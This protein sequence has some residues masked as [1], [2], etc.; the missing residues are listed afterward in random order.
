MAQ[1]VDSIVVEF[2]AETDQ[3][4]RR[5]GKVIAL[6]KELNRTGQQM[7]AGQKEYADRHNAAGASIAQA[8]EQTTAR[9]TRTRRKR[10]DDS[11]ALDRRETDAAKRAAKERADAEIAEAQRSARL[12]E[13]ARRGAE[14]ANAGVPRATNSTLGRTV[15][16]EA[17][18]Q[19]G[20]PAAVL[21]GGAEEVAA[22]KEV[23]RLNVDLLD[24]KDKQGLASAKDA[25]LLGEKIAELRYI[26]SLEREGVD[27]AEIAL[28][29]DE[30][31]ALVAA[32]L[33]RDERAAAK[34]GHG[35]GGA[36]ELAL[37]VTGGRF[38][39]SFSAGAVAGFG[40][41]IA[42][43]IT[44]EAVRSSIDYA[45]SLKEQSD[46]LGLTTRSLQ[47]YGM[48]ASQAGATQD[49]LTSG[50][51]Q[52]ASNL[53]RA[54]A[55]AEEQAKMFR[56]LGIDIGDARRG[57]ASTDAVLATVVERLSAIPNPARRA[58]IELELFGGAGRQLDGLLSG[59][60][61][62]VNGLADSMERAGNILSAS[63]IAKLQRAGQVLDEVK[64]Q[65]QVSVSRTVADNAEAIRDLARAFGSIVQGAG[66]ALQALIRF[67][68]QMNINVE[69]SA[70]DGW[71]TS[72]ER[73]EQARRNIAGYQEIIRRNTP[74]YVSFQ[75][76]LE[77]QFEA[78]ANFGRP[79]PGKS[80][81]EALDKLFSPKAPK[82]P[83]GKSAHQLQDETERRADRQRAILE[84]YEDERLRAVQQQTADEE[85]RRDIDR[86][87]IDRDLAREKL[88]LQAE[89]RAQIRDGADARATTAWL[90]RAEAAAEAAAGERAQVI[91]LDS[92]LA[93]LNRRAATAT[94]AL[95]LDDE[96]L[97][98]QLATA[99]T[100]AER[101]RIEL[102]LLENARKRETV[103]ANLVFSRAE[104][105][106]PTI[107]RQD[108]NDA[109]R[110][111][112]TQDA[113]FGSAARATARNNESPLE[114][115]RRQLHEATDDTNEALE[116]IQVS[117]LQRLE[118]EVANT[119]SSVLGL[120]GAF[121]D[122]VSS[123]LVDLARLE[124]KKGILSLFRGGGGGD[125]AL[126][127]LIRTGANAALGIPGLATG[128]SFVVGGNGGIDRN[129][130]S[131]NG[132]PVARVNR[133]ERVAVIPPDLGR[134]NP[135]AVTPTVMGGGTITL[136]VD[137]GEYFDARVANVSGPIA[138]NTSVKVFRAGAP[139]L[140]AQT[141]NATPAKL[142]QTRTLEG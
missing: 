86:R 88:D 117:G 139:G 21:T 142:S 120:K 104:N 13:V 114:S 130:M 103:A 75:E 92:L 76:S 65:L 122:L 64:Q 69:Q 25:R 109:N 24:L 72:P 9:V 6:H 63:D 1:V 141:L 124:I 101:R 85:E 19:R 40:G 105:G 36:N 94:A 136:H 32:K 96:I 100:I 90:A 115:Y 71:F 28:K 87:Q 113:R 48:A 67:K 18:G 46:A 45:R 62:K 23:N 97:R 41:A 55:G 83:R 38:G 31:R 84:R 77:R 35:L 26:K 110:T 74:G 44:V 20:I 49:Q 102:Q 91:N 15:P 93:S 11:I 95:D 4:E 52:L 108:I 42:A 134:I 128:G 131:I 68:A 137:A 2:I 99:T 3:Y 39:Y 70:L 12:S 57:F 17:S 53:G 73:K 135:P 98:D 5:V 107:T 30:R 132:Q 79:Q 37:G 82:G 8:E 14:R 59:G 111:L 27:Q 58:L 10:V 140:V 66:A 61:D 7:A 127:A 54:Q 126:G 16:R 56:A 81:P 50:L 47:V 138:A 29:L 119:A 116:R 43:G 51:G 80:D 89:A 34:R 60:I 129:L 125:D 133:G 33:A 112:A 121:G 22:A 78:I 118:D 106:D 123:I